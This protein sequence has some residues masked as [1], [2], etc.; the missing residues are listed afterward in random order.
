MMMMMI[1]SAVTRRIRTTLFRRRR[2]DDEDD[3]DVVDRLEVYFLTSRSA[4]AA[5]GVCSLNSGFRTSISPVCKS[6]AGN[7]QRNKR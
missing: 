6:I 2:R 1:G 7:L 3:D 5:T 4:G